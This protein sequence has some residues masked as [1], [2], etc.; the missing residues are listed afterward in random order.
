MA[1][2]ITLAEVQHHMPESGLFAS[3]DYDLVLS[4]LISSVSRLI[5]REVGGEPNF[6]APTTDNVTRYYDGSGLDEQEI[7][8][9]IAITEL[10]VSEYGYLSSSDF[11]VWQSADYLTTPYNALPIRALL[12]DRLTG[13]KL[14]FPNYRKSIRVTGR[15]GYS[16]SPP[17]DIKQAAMIQVIRWFMRAKQGYAT[18]GANP[19]AGSI[20]VNV[21]NRAGSSPRLDPDVAAL[22]WPYKVIV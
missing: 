8:P 6:F 15:F 16:E 14:R 19:E 4:G 21:N 12:V 1:D 20:T 18:N 22:L 3:T 2:Y 7:E 13:D 9:A 11:T 17:D 10:A 5:D